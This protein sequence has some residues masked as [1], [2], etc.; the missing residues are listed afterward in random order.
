M[1]GIRACQ[2]NHKPIALLRELVLLLAVAGVSCG[3]GSTADVLTGEPADGGGAGAVSS[4]GSG[5]MP[6][7][8]NTG[9]PGDERCILPPDP[10]L[11]LQFHYGPSNYSDP[12]EVEKYLLLPGQ[13]GTDCVFFP[14]PGATDMN[15]NTYHIRMRPGSYHVLLYLQ[16]IGD[17]GIVTSDGPQACGQGLQSRKPFGSQAAVLDVNAIGG[18][19]PEDDSLAIRIQAQPQTVM[20]LYFINA[21]ATPLLREAWVNVLFAPPR[22]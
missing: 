10:T 14:T 4:P 21:G 18:A 3:S 8:I 22:R 9:Y 2:E 11:G 5:T 7:S 6:C 17:N 20:Q 16:P 15:F 12:N 13:E 1:A 19:T